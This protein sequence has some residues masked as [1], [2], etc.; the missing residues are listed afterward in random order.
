MMP[1]ELPQILDIPQI[2]MVEIPLLP[3]NNGR[4]Q[5]LGAQ[6]GVSLARKLNPSLIEIPLLVSAVFH[7]SRV[8]FGVLGRKEDPVDWTKAGEEGLHLRGLHEWR[9]AAEVAD[10]GFCGFF[11]GGGEGVGG[12]RRELRVGVGGF[13]GASQ[14]LAVGEGLLR[15]SFGGGG[16]G[17]VGAGVFG[18]G[19][20]GLGIGVFGFAA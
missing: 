8:G 19:G 15:E 5:R 16:G 12:E 9:H 13:G 1:L 2:I 17:G 4:I 6:L 7:P 14:A 10:A 18:I 3:A 11:G 20:V